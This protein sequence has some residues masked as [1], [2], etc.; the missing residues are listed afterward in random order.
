MYA[1]R[2]YYAKL[3]LDSTLNYQNHALSTNTY[4][5]G[6]SLLIPNALATHSKFVILGFG[7]NDLATGRTW[8]QVLSDLDAIKILFDASSS[9]KFRITSYNVCY[10]KLL[11]FDCFHS[12]RAGILPACYPGCILRHCRKLY[13][14]SCCNKKW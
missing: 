4:A 14:L 7:S 10:T 2:S 1:I 11:R 9:E 6:L 12:P 8:A 5:N 13:W 3:A